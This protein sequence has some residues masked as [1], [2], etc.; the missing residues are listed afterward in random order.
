MLGY[1]FH[2][3]TIRFFTFFPIDVYV[4]GGE[5]D[6]CVSMSIRQQKCMRRQQVEKCLAGTQFADVVYVPKSSFRNHFREY[7]F[8]NTSQKM[9]KF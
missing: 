3:N 8:E 9:L 2:K 1:A 7:K 5:Y 4:L 6:S